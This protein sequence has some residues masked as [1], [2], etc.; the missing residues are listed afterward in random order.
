MFAGGCMERDA[1]LAVGLGGRLS[2]PDRPVLSCLA[3]DGLN[4][5]DSPLSPALTGQY[6]NVS[7]WWRNTLAIIV[8]RDWYLL[9][10]P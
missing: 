6:N 3:L 7:L 2:D 10:V 4:A 5:N 1:T 8:I 9:M